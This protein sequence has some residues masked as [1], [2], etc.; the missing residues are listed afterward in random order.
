MRTISATFLALLILAPLGRSADANATA[1]K[2]DQKALYDRA[3][4]DIGTIL[5][6]P[7]TARFA[8]LGTDEEARVTEI[9]N[10]VIVVHGYVDAENAFSALLRKEWDV[11]F[12]ATDAGTEIVAVRFGDDTVGDIK[13]VVDF[14]NGIDPVHGFRLKDGIQV[15]GKALEAQRDAFLA[16]KRIARRTDYHQRAKAALLNWIQPKGD[17]KHS[18]LLPADDAFTVCRELGNGVWEARGVFQ[19]SGKQSPWRVLFQGRKDG[20]VEAIFMECSTRH[21]GTESAALRIVGSQ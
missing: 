16:E 1:V 14:A 17:V 15:T 19:A 2:T 21:W 18:Q 5:I 6:A 8:K 13:G 4:T 9:G 20:S 10:G 3:T 7:A 12:R 11:Y